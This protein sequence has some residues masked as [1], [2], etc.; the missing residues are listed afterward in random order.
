MTDQPRHVPTGDD[1]VSIIERVVR[2]LGPE[3]YA[4]PEELAA[5]ADR[6]PAD[7]WQVLADV[8]PEQLILHLYAAGLLT[9]DDT[10]DRAH[11]RAT[12]AAMTRCLARLAEFRPLE[13]LDLVQLRPTHQAYLAGHQVRRTM[14]MDLSARIGAALAVLDTI[15]DDSDG[16][17][18]DIRT[19]LRGETSTGEI[20][21]DLPAAA[22]PDDPEA[23]RS[24]IGHHAPGGRGVQ[25][26]TGLPRGVR[27]GWTGKAGLSARPGLDMVQI[28]ARWRAAQSR[29]QRDTDSSFVH[30]QRALE[31]IRPYIERAY[32]LALIEAAPDRDAV[33]AAVDLI[34]SASPPVVE[35]A[36]APVPGARPIR[37][38]DGVDPDASQDLWDRLGERRRLKGRTGR[39]LDS[40]A[41]PTAI[42]QAQAGITWVAPTSDRRPGMASY[43]LSMPGYLLGSDQVTAEIRDADG[44]YVCTQRDDDG[45]EWTGVGASKTAALLALIADRAGYTATVTAHG[46]AR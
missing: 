34:A 35:I 18:D 4:T 14:I 33:K 36:G 16:L 6:A 1:A 40:G 5:G 17:L 25:A 19:M 12:W 43:N 42:A 32:A 39:P 20:L 30:D 9:L 37:L 29:P 31:E 8:R 26:G 38:V 13:P 28:T 41:T 22:S 11:L 10:D 45:R 46:A 3:W 21:A 24:G 7:T 15:R 27:P 2:T 44:F 23:P